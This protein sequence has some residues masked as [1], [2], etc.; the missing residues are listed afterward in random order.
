MKKALLILAILFFALGHSQDAPKRQRINNAVKCETRGHIEGK[1][2]IEPFRYVIDKKNF[3]IVVRCSGHVK[4]ECLRCGD[5]ITELV[6]ERRD[7][8]PF[9]SILIKN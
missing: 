9:K 8:I 5:T 1:M 2:L 7:T 6:P 4:Y 3:T